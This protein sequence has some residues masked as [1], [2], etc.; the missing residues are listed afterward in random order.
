MPFRVLS[1]PPPP[2]PFL[3]SPISRNDDK[4]F[5]CIIACWRLARCLYEED[6]IALRLLVVDLECNGRW[7]LFFFPFHFP[8]AVISYS[9][10]FKPFREL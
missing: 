2:F 5:G 8:N 4:T 1:L 9:V 10:S 7:L 6:M 3:F